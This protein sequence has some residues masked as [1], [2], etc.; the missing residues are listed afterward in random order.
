MIET[1][2]LPSERQRPSAI[3]LDKSTL[4]AA[5]QAMQ[6]AFNELLLQDPTLF[7]I[8]TKISAANEKMVVF[9]G[10]A[11]DRLLEFL[12]GKEVSSRD[13]D[14][15]VD[16]ERHVAE[17]FPKDALAN[18]FG[19]VGIRGRLMPLE[20]WN[21]HNT[22]LFKRQNRHATFDA[23]PTTADYGVNALVF[24]PSQCHGMPSIM[25]LGA[26]IALKSS[27]LDFMADEVAQPKI[28]AARAVI[29]ATKLDL[30]LSETVCDF[31]QDVCENNATAKEVQ[32]A[33]HVYCPVELRTS[34]LQLL[35]RIRQGAMGGR[36]KTELFFHCWGVFE[37]GGVRA[38]AHAGAYA[39]AKR[40]GVTFSRVAGTSGGSIVAA[41]VAA[42]ATPAYLRQHLQ[43]LDF[44]PLL[45]QPSKKNIFFEKKL[46]FWARVLKPFTWGDMRRLA[47][48]ATYGGLYDSKRLGDWIEQRLVE[49]LRGNNSINKKPVLFSELPLPLHVVATDFSNGQPKIWSSS[50]T[51]EESVTLAVRYSCSIP[52]FFQPAPAGASIFLDG[53]AVSNL[54]AY[55][56]NKQSQTSD[57]RDVLTRILAFRLVEDDTRSKPVQDLKDFALRMSATVIDSASEIQL[58]LQPNVY[59]VQIKTGSISSTDFD[60]IDMKS[61]RFLY[62]RGMIGVRSFIEKEKLNSIRHDSAAQEFRGFDEQMLLV[63]HQMRSCAKTLV[64]MGSDT[65]WLDHVFPSLLLLL[66][67]GIS[68]AMVVSPVKQLHSDFQEQEE[69]RR[70]LLKLLGVLVQETTGNLPFTGFAFDLG[71]SRASAILTHLPSDAQN[72]SRYESENVR[73]YTTDNDPAILS[74]LA[75]HAKPYLSL[76]KRTPLTLEYGTR[77]ESNLISRLRQIPAYARATI[78]IQNVQV[79]RDIFVMQKRVKE[80]KALQARYFLTDL[81]EREQKLFGATS[82]QLADGGSSIVTPPVLERHSGSLVLIEGAARLHYCFTNGIEE[83]Q[84]VVID[85]VTE[86]LPSDGHF[87]LA[88][89]RLVSSTMS[90]ASNYQN[91]KKSAYRAIERVVHES[92]D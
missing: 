51:A 85:G 43:E 69:R 64:L 30:I 34:T 46:P 31:I 61:K 40:A 58:Q 56:L 91:Y 13:I 78:T 88:S 89:L 50:T 23:L 11:R 55:V 28:Q 80:Y 49:L 19:G 4:D 16:S 83:V 35:A 57:E 62:E 10:W 42:G 66:R 8:L 18:P 52:F 41:L 86:P 36:P 20:A 3:S 24:F 81:L 74:M 77:D 2:Q 38:A 72:K 17:F 39:A 45:D 70:K 48:V 71:T 82:V 14:F 73:L 84:A 1:V 26:G 59:P 27:I 22:F 68:L 5:A 12:H 21:L 54:P 7:E 44:L 9:G 79:T 47:N 67:R 6:K 60:R 75:S 76:G 29:L 33:I 63:V 53:G 87:S 15:V 32:A 25:D 37:G 90:I 65:Y 92:Y